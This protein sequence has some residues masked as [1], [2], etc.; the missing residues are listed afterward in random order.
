MSLEYDKGDRRF[1][2]NIVEYSNIDDIDEDLLA[3][4]K[5]I[6]NVRS[7]VSKR[8]IWKPAACCVTVN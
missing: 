7:D 4:Y 3:E 2:E 8:K 5:K 1:E 6:K